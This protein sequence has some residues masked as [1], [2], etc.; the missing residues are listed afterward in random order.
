MFDPHKNVVTTHLMLIHF[1]PQAQIIDFLSYNFVQGKPF[2]LKS[3]CLYI[4]YKHVLER[5]EVFSITISSL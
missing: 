3:Q 1:C 4:L 5:D 2:C